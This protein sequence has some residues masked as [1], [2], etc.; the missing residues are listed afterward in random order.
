MLVVA[1][2]DPRGQV[3]EAVQGNSGGEGQAPKEETQQRQLEGGIVLD[4]CG[5]LLVVL[6]R[7]LSFSF[8]AAPWLP[9][10]LPLCLRLR[11][12][13][14]L[15]L[16]LSLSAVLVFIIAAVGTAA[17][18]IVIAIAI[19][20]GVDGEAAEQLVELGV[21]DLIGPVG[22]Q[23]GRDLELG[24]ERADEDALRQVILLDPH[25][26][27]AA[28][29]A[30]LARPRR[31]LEEAPDKAQPSGP[32]VAVALVYAARQG[33][34]GLYRVVVGGGCRCTRLAVRV[35]LLIVLVVVVVVVIS[36]NRIIIIIVI[37]LAAL[38]AACCGRYYW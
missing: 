17:N 5:E 33:A 31:A 28:R 2:P 16:S 25:G 38:A 9:P 6:A 8:L 4:P 18:V 19:A 30:L 21:G 13:P 14:C 10:W 36:A 27:E 29:R 7:A 23:G 24:V 35:G 12:C 22:E 11:L 20:V 3:E 34:E 32:D 37:I 26:K 1:A 15:S